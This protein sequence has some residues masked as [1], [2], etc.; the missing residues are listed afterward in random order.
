MAAT[1]IKS[2]EAVEATVKRR[3]FDWIP[4]A[5]ILPHLIFFVIFAI[6]KSPKTLG[7]KN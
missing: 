6:R 5:F 3:Y 7:R 1:T 4:Y 2:G